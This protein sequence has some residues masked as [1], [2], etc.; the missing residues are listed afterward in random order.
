MLDLI[1]VTLQL[2]SAILGCHHQVTI[3]RPRTLVTQDP[4]GLLQQRLSLGQPHHQSLPV[5]VHAVLGV[6]HHHQHRVQLKQDQSST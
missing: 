2:S 4:G 5:L 3:L 6:S 1:D